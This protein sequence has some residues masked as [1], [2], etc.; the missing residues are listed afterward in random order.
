MKSIK[1]AA[2]ASNRFAPYLF[3]LML[4]KLSIRENILK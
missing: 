4:I 3:S 1:L 2:H